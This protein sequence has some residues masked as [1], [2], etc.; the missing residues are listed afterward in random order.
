[1]KKNNQ[2]AKFFPFVLCL[3]IVF[4]ASCSP[5]GANNLPTSITIPSETPTVE[6]LPPTATV[7]PLPTW[8]S[9]TPYYS[10]PRDEMLD[11]ACRI[12]INLFFRYK[13]GDSLQSYRDLFTPE[14][15]YRADSIAPSA[16]AGIILELM[17]ASD[18]WLRD[19][20]GTPMPGTIFP[21]K[22]NEYIYYVKFTSLNDQTDD[23]SDYFPPSSMKMIMVA[24]GPNSCKIANYGNG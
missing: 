16:D 23:P 4:V 22:P 11:T 21:E 17:P 9:P 20:P 15:K 24:D 14:A 8:P 2:C 12:T 5:A 7:E 19:F 13:K 18:E 3:L 1:M 10:A 6:E